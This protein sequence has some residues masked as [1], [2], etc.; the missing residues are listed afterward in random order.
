MAD[1]KFVL[2]SFLGTLLAHRYIVHLKEGAVNMK[3]TVNMQEKKRKGLTRMLVG[4]FCVMLAGGTVN[5]MAGGGNNLTAPVFPTLREELAGNGNIA[6]TIRIYKMFV[7]IDDEDLYAHYELGNAY[8]YAGEYAKAEVEYRRA[9]SLDPKFGPAYA[10]LGNAL[11]M[12]NRA[13]EALKVYDQSIEISKG[14]LGTNVTLWTMVARTGSIEMAIR[15]FKY[16]L[17]SKGQLGSSYLGLGI[18]QAASRMNQDAVR[19]FQIALRYSPSLQQAYVQ[20]GKV[21]ESIGEHSKALVAFAKASKL[22]Q[23]TNYTQYMPYTA[24]VTLLA[25]AR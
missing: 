2:I 24:P 18:A 19:S 16:K 9:V 4:V 14:E 7:K 5:M 6:R 22:E 11:V 20:L 12:M 17:E 1:K 15:A 3:T 23:P 21:Y 8:T 13:G 10:G 25:S